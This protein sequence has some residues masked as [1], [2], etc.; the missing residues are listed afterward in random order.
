[1]RTLVR[2]AVAAVWTL[3]L[4]G[5]GDRGASAEDGNGITKLP[6]ATVLANSLTAFKAAP[7]YQVEIH[8]GAENGS[9]TTRIAVIGTN[10]RGTVTRDGASSDVLKVGANYY[11]RPD[12]AFWSTMLDKPTSAHAYTAS[13][14]GRWIKI[15]GSDDLLRRSGLKGAFAFATRTALDGAVP[16]QVSLGERKDVGGVPT[17]TVLD[18]R[19]TSSN[20]TQVSVAT[21][22]VPYPIRW[23][24][25]LGAVAD[26]TNFGT[27]SDAME[28]PAPADVVEM[29]AVL[30]SS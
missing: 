3:L 27:T 2:A 28:Q 1:M 8:S 18:S 29:S 10:C 23:D 11:I 25:G 26:F 16:Q 7:S 30:H 13:T 6:A 24:F 9:S 19:T 20:Q 21:T 15:D 12:E 17:V 14:R 22:G 5:C 4:V